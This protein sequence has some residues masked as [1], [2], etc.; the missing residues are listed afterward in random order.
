MDAF[1]RSPVTG[2]RFVA[3]VWPGNSVFLDWFHPNSTE[4]WSLKFND[5]SKPV[6]FDGLWVDM[7][8][9]SSFCQGECYDYDISKKSFIYE[10]EEL[11]FHPSNRDPSRNTIFLEKKHYDG[12]TEF[13]RHSLL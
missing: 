2:K 13:S 7:N 1:L 12:S 9:P 10:K 6:P 5:L 8:E 3:K 11:S 4:Y